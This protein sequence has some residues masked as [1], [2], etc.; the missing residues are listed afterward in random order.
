VSSD[1]RARPIASGERIVPAVNA[2]DLFLLGRRLMQIA[3]SVLPQG[4]E[5]TSL[6]LVL[7]DIAYHPGSSI[8]QIT[9]RTGFP[10]SLVSM[11]VSRLRDVGVVQTEPDPADR[12]RTLVRPTAKLAQRGQQGAGGVSIQDA[13]AGALAEEDRQELAEVIAALD[14]LANKLLPD[15][16]APPP[17]QKAG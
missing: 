12:R 5:P 16:P 3:E 8:T 1:L 6:R 14:L 9:E 7:I 17:S 2:T 10:Q 11:S 15:V 13:V 4:N